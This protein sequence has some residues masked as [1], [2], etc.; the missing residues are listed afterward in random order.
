MDKRPSSAPWV[1]AT[2]NGQ[3]TVS[4]QANWDRDDNTLTYTLR[5]QDLAQPLVT[6]KVRSQFWNRPISTFVDSGL[7]VGARYRYT[8][9]ATDPD[10][11]TWTSAV[12]PFQTSG[13]PSTIRND[14]ASHQW[15]L[16]G[17]PGSATEADQAGPLPLTLGSQV[18]L[19]APGALDD[20]TATAASVS[21]AGP[22]AG[23][24]STTEPATAQSSVELWFK[25]STAGGTLA[26]FGGGDSTAPTTRSRELYLTPS[27]R[28]AY[29]V[30]GSGA[31]GADAVFVASA[32]P[33]TDGAWHHATAVQTAD[34]LLLYLDGVLATS[35]DTS[36][37]VS[38][39]GLWWVGGATPSDL[40]NAGSAAFTG[41]VD[42]VAV[43]PSALSA[44]QI[45]AHYLLV[46]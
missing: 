28:L 32:G 2:G 22:I 23:Y 24:T 35:V 15:R 5:R 36:V 27:G 41:T 17:R 25:T 19:G 44:A 18:T 21:G 37:A 45:S 3:A 20:E 13:Y 12:T 7:E 4:W 39:A 16:D 29:A 42:E 46:Q 8:V 9:T 11:N 43:Y 38:D 6:R 31:V 34:Q 40:V 30:R 14:G 26:A 10:G 1:V 33:V